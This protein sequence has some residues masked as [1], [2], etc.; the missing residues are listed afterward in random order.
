MNVG[1]NIDYHVDFDGHAYSVPHALRQKGRAD[2][3]ATDAVVEPGQVLGAVL[4]HRPEP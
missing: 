2:I 1:V 3:R 4:Q